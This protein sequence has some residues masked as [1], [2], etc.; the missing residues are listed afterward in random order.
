MSVIVL[1]W[2]GW[3]DTLDCLSSLEKLDYP[4][5]KMVVVDNG[6]TDGSEENIRT[7]YPDIEILQSGGN[8]GFAGGNNIGIKYAL[9][10]GTDYVWLLNNDTVVDPAALTALVEEALFGSFIGMVGSKVYYYEPCDLIWFAGGTVSMVTGKTE[11][12]LSR[13]RDI[14][15]HYQSCDVD[16]VTAC[17]ML[18]S[19]EAIGSIGLLDTRFFLYYEETDWAM[20]AKRNGWRVRYQPT[21]KVWHKVSSSS[22]LN[23]ST[24]VF[25]FAKSSML[26]ARK[27]IS[28][29]PIL[30]FLV[31]IR[32]QVLPFLVRGKF[33]TAAAG[34]RGAR[35]GLKDAV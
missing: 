11:H 16:Y 23:S 2:N 19:R 4:N 15:Q 29:W 18:V 9:E 22:V 32:H 21:S 8:L 14:G 5:Y 12:L 34:I 3:Q 28:P 33:S 1:N 35:A 27:H 24:M 13:Q 31:T 20:R 10:Q 26:F 7:A 30:P 17:S 25:H 6:S